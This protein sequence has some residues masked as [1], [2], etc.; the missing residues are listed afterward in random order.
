MT[1]DERTAHRVH[2]VSYDVA[3]EVPPYRVVGTVYLY[4][5]SEPDRLL[6]RSSDMFVPVVDASAFLGETAHRASRRRRR[7][8]STASTCAASSRSTSGRGS[9]TRSCPGRR[10]AG[11]TGPTGRADPALSRAGPRGQ[12]RAT[13]LTRGRTRKPALAT[14]AALGVPSTRSA[15]VSKSLVIFSL[16]EHLD[17]RPALVGGADE[18]QAARADRAPAPAS[19]RS[20]PCPRPVTPL[21]ARLTTIASR[22]RQPSPRGDVAQLD[23]G[24]DGRHVRA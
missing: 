5:G 2:K 1:D 14:G 24:A 21:L 4:P 12:A 7:S 15:R 13:S 20:S 16:R 3:L 10:W 23:G 17:D 18:E 6:D 11:P 22:S 9:A 8:S 19:R